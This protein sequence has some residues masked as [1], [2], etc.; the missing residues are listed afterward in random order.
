MKKLLITMISIF[1]TAM[2]LTGCENTAAGFGKD[3][4]N[5][6]RAITKAVNG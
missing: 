2:I 1:T 6:G 5:T 3:M 4:Q